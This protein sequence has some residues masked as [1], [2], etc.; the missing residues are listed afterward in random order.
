MTSKKTSNLV[1]FLFLIVPILGYLLW[2]LQS[3]E[4]QIEWD[5]N[6]MEVKAQLLSNISQQTDTTSRPNIILILADDLGKYDISLYGHPI[7]RT[8]NIDRLAKSGAR[9]E[10]GYV[11]ASVCAP[12][13][14]GLLTGRYQHRFG[15]ASQ[16]QENYLDNRL[17]YYGMNAFIDSYPWKIKRMDK[18][19]NAEAMAKQGLPPSEIT[20][21]DA[22]K[23]KGYKTALIGKWHLGKNKGQTPCDFGF[24]YQYGFYASHSLFIPENTKGYVD[25]KNEN[26]WTDQYIW[27]GQREGVHAVRR[28]CQIIQEDRYFTDAIS[29]EAIQFINKN[30]QPYFMYLPFNAPHTPLQASEK[31]VAIYKEVKDPIKRIYYAMITS[32]DRAIGNILD[33]VERKGQTDNTLIF[34][35]SDN[36]GATYTHTTDNDPLEGGKM[37]AFDGGL[38]I[39]FIM[40]WPE[41]VPA[42]QAFDEPVISLDIFQTCLSAANI[43]T[44]LNR[45]IDGLDLMNIVNGETESFTTRDLFW[46]S[47]DMTTVLDFPYKLIH[48]KERQQTM[49]YKIDTDPYEESNLVDQNK[50]MVQKLLIKQQ[51]WHQ[52][53]PKPMWPTMIEFIHE[54]DGE[55]YYF[56]N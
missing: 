51:N 21:G 8:P 31:D 25:Q 19:P 52:E 3:D 10:Q 7:V 35:L 16:T 45:K 2:P 4:F 6:L 50:S 34:L 15:F 29:E 20:I 43:T 5:V 46:N 30:E 42:N 40:K 36:G 17:Q 39:P 11:S 56:D 44:P 24:D 32:L 54:K 23:A 9:F 12:S 18:V 27:E 1:L 37:T 53:L 55:K 38:Q 48:M 14:A 28:N 41:K 22:L 47:G 13:R 33:E 49:L 26:D